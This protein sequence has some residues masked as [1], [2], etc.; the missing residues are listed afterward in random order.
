MFRPCELTTPLDWHGLRSYLGG[1]GHELDLSSPARQFAGGLG[2]LNF[3]ITVDGK[4][5]VLRRPPLGPIPRGANDMAREHQVLRT[6]WRAYPWAPQS[7]LYCADPA[8]LGA[9]FLIMAYQ[10]GL[11]I[12]GEMPSEIDPAQAGPVL[13]AHLVSLLAALHGVPMESVGLGELGRPDGFLE[14]ACEGWARRAGA[15][16]ESP[17]DSLLGELVGWLRRNKVPDGAPTL[18]HC[19]FKLD[20]VVLDPHSLK[21]M[22]VLDWDMS[23]RGDP[24]FDVATLLSYWTEA[25]DPPAVQALGQMPTALPG[26]WSRAQVLQEYSKATGRDL[27]DFLF[28]RV[29]ALFKLGVV[30]LQLHARF[31]SGATTDGR[32]ARFGALGRD[33]LD[34]SL[35]VARGRAH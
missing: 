1:L 3:L 5:C 35:C 23:T 20:N 24:L 10:P 9:H 19:D 18:L 29:L 14:R 22:A 6:L 26:F 28:Y 25:T 33:I 34:F 12:G 8:V 15:A 31:R 30:F 2:N 13:S 17:N 27:S 21:P 4:P 7:L 32:Y 11:V 16:A